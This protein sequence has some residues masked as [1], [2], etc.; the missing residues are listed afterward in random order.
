M[1]SEAGRGE[2]ADRLGVPARCG[3][4]P[5][6]RIRPS[7]R[8]STEPAKV[9]L[10]SGSTSRGE[11]RAIGEAR[12]ATRSASITSAETPAS[13]FSNT[14]H[15]QPSSRARATPAF[16]PGPKP[17]LSGIGTRFQPRS[18]VRTAIFSRSAALE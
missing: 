5:A 2:P 15:S 3:T 1:N 7:A 14:K 6:V 11:I 16:T 9:I 12:L 10:P 18:A 8:F 17:R 4:G 13:G